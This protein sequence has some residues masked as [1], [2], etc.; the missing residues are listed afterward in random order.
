[1]EEVEKEEGAAAI[2]APDWRRWT[3]RWV[4]MKV[5]EIKAKGRKWTRRRAPRSARRE[6]VVAGYMAPVLTQRG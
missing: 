4:F 5:V 1:M 2:R 3:G 6:V